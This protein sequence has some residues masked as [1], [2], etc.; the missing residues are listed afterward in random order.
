MINIKIE[1]LFTGYWDH[2]LN[3]LIN[4]SEEV[5]ALT[6]VIFGKNMSHGKDFDTRYLLMLS[7]LF[8]KISLIIVENKNL[9]YFNDLE[10]S[11]VKATKTKNLIF[12]V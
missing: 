10:V 11:F 3:F 5:L 4:K 6:L 1:L 12:V 8:K 9:I 7:L 2:K